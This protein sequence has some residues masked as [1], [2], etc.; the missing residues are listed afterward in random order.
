MEKSK[1]SERIYVRCTS[2]QKSLITEKAESLNMNISDFM[3]LATTKETAVSTID[4][5]LLRDLNRIGNNL[6]QLVGYAHTYKERAYNNI[7]SDRLQGIDESLKTL[8]GS[9][10]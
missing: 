5:T 4:P 2:E 6:N 9:L 1:K 10:K 3:L 8:L 7:F